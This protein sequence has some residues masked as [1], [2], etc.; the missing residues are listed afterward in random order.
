MIKKSHLATFALLLVLPVSI[1][2][3]WKGVNRELEHLDN[4][5]QNTILK[6]GHY[7]QKIELEI[8]QKIKALGHFMSDTL[9]DNTEAL[10]QELEIIEK[11]NTDIACIG[12]AFKPNSFIDS[13]VL[14]A[15]RYQKKGANYEWI[16][17]DEYWDYTDEN[18][19]NWYAEIIHKKKPFH[20]SKPFI[21]PILNKKVIQYSL[22][23]SKSDSLGRHTLGV[24]YFQ[25]ALDK[26]KELLSGLEYG[27]NGFYFIL[28][29]EQAKTS[30]NIKDHLILTDIPQT[31]NLNERII[32]KYFNES[33]STKTLNFI[34]EER[35]FAFHKIEELNW[36]FVNVRPV[37]DIVYSKELF[38]R[39]GKASMQYFQFFRNRLNI[40]IYVL[41]PLVIL[42]FVF[43]SFLNRQFSKQIGLIAM[44]ITLSIV[45]LS[46]TSYVWVI[47]ESRSVNYHQNKADLVHDQE[48]LAK[49]QRKYSLES[50]D[51]YEVL[52]LYIPTGIFIQSVEFPEKNN[53]KLTGYVW[54][55]Y[56]ILGN[57][58]SIQFVNFE[59]KDELGVIFPD[60]VSLTMEKSY[61]R[62]YE[63]DNLAVLG[64]YYEM[65]LRQNF[66]LSQFPLDYK[67]INIRMWHKQFEQN[68]VLLPDLDAYDFLNPEAKAGIDQQI[69]TT[70]WQLK[71]SF[72]SF[73]RN[74]YN[75]N[76]GFTNYR[77]E[78]NFPEL[79]FV[80]IMQR[81]FLSPFISYVTPILFVAI[82]LFFSVFSIT[83]QAEE[84]EIL[85]FSSSTIIQIVIALFFAALLSHIDL[86]SALPVKGFFY[87]EFF[88]FAIY[89]MLVLVTVNSKLVAFNFHIG[90]YG[91]KAYNFIFKAAFWPTLLFLIFLSTIYILY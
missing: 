70:G 34:F 68:I 58:D 71:G 32:A 49:Y 39:D 90:T 84:A 75:T 66:N 7:V 21:D 91:P 85:G 67:N 55:K 50:L 13:L 37:S 12:L 4:L 31:F 62:F 25:F 23:I 16:N 19:Q 26:V 77:G 6:A 3:I 8:A 5:E 88:Y 45:F 65:E 46:A 74:S 27:E 64:W 51:K 83:G 86:R 63:E 61:E 18:I 2:L 44:S 43:T 29:G 78:E 10:F 9:L 87:L 60:A 81:E 47:C 54:Q 79:N 11:Q 17:I 73:D 24:L 35:I 20:W 40:L 89:L 52:P 15:P 33:D 53:I 69:V 1:Y 28:D 41:I 57:R 30:E 72:F 22:P 80:I 14:V 82:L 59:S 36:V 38:I 56:H 42:I 48:G 76:F